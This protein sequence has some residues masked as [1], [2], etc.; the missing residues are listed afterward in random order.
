MGATATGSP[1]VAMTCPSRS[2]SW[3]AARSPLSTA[4][5]ESRSRRPA[6]GPRR[7]GTGRPSGGRR[8]AAGAAV[9]ADGRRRGHRRGR[10]GRGAD[11][12]QRRAVGSGAPPEVDLAVDPVDGTTLTAKSRPDA[13]AVIAV[14]ER[15][16][17]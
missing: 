8:H 12:L 9:G 14:A 5:A 16:T 17:M 6:D 15:G 11:A 1:K 4:D 2:S 7:Q 3:A 10:E 13:I